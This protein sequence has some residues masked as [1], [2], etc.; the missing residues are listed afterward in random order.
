MLLVRYGVDLTISHEGLVQ[1]IL[2][3]GLDFSSAGL[4]VGI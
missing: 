1:I 2:G 4:D 3:D